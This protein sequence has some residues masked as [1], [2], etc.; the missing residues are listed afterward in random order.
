MSQV[1]AYNILEAYSLTSRAY[2]FNNAVI[3]QNNNLFQ[4][5]PLYQPQIQI[6]NVNNNNIININN[7]NTNTNINI[8]NSKPK[9]KKDAL[10]Q[11]D[12]VKEYMTDSKYK[13]ELCK[14]FTQNGF[15]PY[16]NKCRFAH[17]KQDLFDKVI[18]CKKYK[19]KE[20][21]SFFKNLHC[22]YGTRCH[23][24]HD[25]RRLK[26]IPKES[27]YQMRLKLIEASFNSV[28]SDNDDKKD[29]FDMEEE[30]V[31]KL[32]SAGAGINGLNKK[33]SLLEKINNEKMISAG[34]EKIKSQPKFMLTTKN[35]VPL[36]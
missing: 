23:F 8:N 21:I 11:V 13:T 5:Q 4:T 6:N 33:F 12:P 18:S 35:I 7:N 1:L 29:V 14:T 19:Q 24:K 9:L 3:Q 10:E 26:D 28:N 22:C 16:G 30:E 34:I 20:C 2:M 27:N 31:T 17:G 36:F 32:V 25:E 15:C